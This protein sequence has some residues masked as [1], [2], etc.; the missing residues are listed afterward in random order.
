AE[1]GIRDFHVTGV[2]TCALPLSRCVRDAERSCI[3]AIVGGIGQERETSR[4]KSPDDLRG[5]DPDVQNERDQE[6][7]AAGI[8]AVPMQTVPVSSVAMSPVS[9]RSSFPRTGGSIGFLFDD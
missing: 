3:T 7:A 4:E 8:L 1:D 2:Q 6:V 5:R 9:R